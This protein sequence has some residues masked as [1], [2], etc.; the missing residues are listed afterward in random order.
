[1]SGA[2]IDFDG[3]ASDPARPVGIDVATREFLRAWFR[4][5]NQTFFPSLNR[6]PAA[7]AAF[8]E[9]GMD[10]NVA[11][12]RCIAVAE[13]DGDKLADAGVL[14]RYDP[15]IARHV[16]LRRQ[17]G[18]RR[19]SLVGLTHALST[20]GAMEAVGALATAPVQSWDALICPSHA[21]RRAALAV[22]DGWQDYLESRFG[23][24]AQIPL[25][26]PV[27]PLGV[28]TVRFDKI[29]TDVKRAEQR[30]RLGI[31]DNVVCVLYVGRL[32]FLAKAN[33]LPL[34]L[35]AEQA[36][37]RLE[38]RLIVV[39]NGYFNDTE[40]ERAFAEAIQATTKKAEARII[41][42]GD[43]DFPDGLWA[44][45]DIF[46]SP[47]DS[48]QESF[49]L[50]P[51]EAMASGLPSVVSDWDGYRETVRDNID[52]I[53]VPTLAAP[54]GAGAAL[55]YDNFVRPGHYGDYLG[56]TAQ[57]SAVDIEALAR[58]LHTLA[59]SDEL[60]RDMGA[61]ARRRAREVFEWSRIIRLYGGLFDELAERR[62][63]A[64]ELGG[65]F[66]GLHP[67]H[68]DPF[69]MFGSFP[70]AHLELAGRVELAGVDWKRAIQRIGLKT[71][72]VFAGSLI[73]LEELPFVIGQMEA[74]P[75]CTV[76]ELA[77]A[78]GAPDRAKLLRTL[79]WLVKL[80]LCRYRAP[81]SKE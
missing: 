46:C 78:L 56:A 26:L 7:L 17:H 11:A 10:D 3:A 68:P 41:K 8:R 71:G 45:A 53:L 55:A 32:N 19:Y 54:P 13:T 22:L 63:A 27:I 25:Y 35:A 33:P 79:T 6:G 2:V 18:Q 14:L 34:L 61:A 23:G 59:V 9:W 21:I 31:D 70:T 42:H 50:T 5:A 66:A 47:I 58:A 75:G 69:T 43:I 76:E 38:K 12:S 60:R 65:D 67:S 57:S 81:A 44:A 80:G 73:E 37:E 28:D 1:M 48:I 49:G 16:W 36:A 40:N 64:P 15:A 30:A 29:T 20:T 62:A 72:L 77:Q 51:L 74:A 24:T 39:F 52:G 4:F